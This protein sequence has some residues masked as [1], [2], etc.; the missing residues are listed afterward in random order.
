MRPKPGGPEEAGCCLLLIDLARGRVPLVGICLGHQAIAHAAGANV[1]R[2]SLP[3]HG[4]TTLIDHDGTG[5]FRGVPSPTRVGRYHSLGV[6]ALPA[7]FHVHARAD[8]VAMAFS[9]P[10]A[11]QV[12]LQFHPESIL[13]PDGDRMLRNVLDDAE[14]A[15]AREAA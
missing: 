9:V 5:P 11:L 15:L 4:K 10:D 2:V 3:V 8:G 7:P 1:A 12:G 6:G 13:T 14:A